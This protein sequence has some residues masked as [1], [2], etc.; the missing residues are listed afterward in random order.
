MRSY[1]ARAMDGQG[2][3]RSTMLQV[4]LRLSLLSLL[5]IGILVGGDGWGGTEGEIAVCVKVPE[6]YSVPQI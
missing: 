6:P 4:V 1:P 2:V 3:G 5:R